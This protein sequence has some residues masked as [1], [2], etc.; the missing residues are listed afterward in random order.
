[1][2]AVTDVIALAGSE[3]REVLALA[4][5]VEHGSSHP[6]ALAIVAEAAAQRL[7]M[8]AAC[9]VK[10][11]P[12]VGVAAT[13]DGRRVFVGKPQS[14]AE[15]PWGLRAAIQTLAANGKTTVVVSA[16]ERPVGLIGLADR[17]RDA[18]PGVLRELKRL[19]IRRT[20]MVT[21]DGRPVAAEM[22]RLLGI[23]D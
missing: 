21:G 2:P 23:D 1:R 10:Q 7:T 19:G 12:A 14:I 5:A 3:E 17:A 4:A 22:S 13:V 16:D 11:V 6:L 18:A 15:L 20:I 9:D 8:P